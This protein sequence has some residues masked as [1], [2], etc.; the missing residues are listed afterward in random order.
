MASRLAPAAVSSAAPASKTAPLV[1]VVTPS[2]QQGRFIGETLRSVAEQDYPHIEHLVLDAGSRDETHDV[3]RAHAE[4]HPRMSWVAEPDRGQSDA[5]NKGFHRARGSIVAWLNADDVY[6]PGAVRAAVE[7]LNAR[8]DAG[9]VYGHGDII[10]ETGRRTGPYVGWEPFHLWRLIHGLDFVLQPATFFR[11]Q[12]VLEL[13]GLDEG[14]NWSMD[15]DLWIRLASVSEVIE[16]DRVLAQAREHGEAKTATGGWRRIREL[17]R[18][19]CR[20]AG[21]SW[22]PGVQ[23][24]AC[25]TLHRQVAAATPRWL[26]AHLA[27]PLQRRIEALMGRIGTRMAQHADGW[28]GREGSLV[29]PRRWGRAR[30]TLAALDVPAGGFE[31]RFLCA[32]R[33][34]ATT[35]FEAPGDQV[36]EF[37][38]PRKTDAA[39]RPSATD[40]H[41]NGASSREASGDE[42]PFATI[43]VRSGHCFRPR[44]PSPDKRWLSVLCRD[45]RAG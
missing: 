14:L 16:L 45:L 34:L 27:G 36:V 23:L 29:V 44:P 37:A 22:T 30:I 32:G 4:R 33:C 5:I 41:A 6:T 38:I 3:L 42:V 17:S 1:T 31:V 2:Y 43:A 10:D 19:A 25:D 39:G 12:L 8:P 18:L 9:L 11:R 35:R 13:G 26:R 24:Y 15:W 21:R 40:S 28:L 7:A 20:H